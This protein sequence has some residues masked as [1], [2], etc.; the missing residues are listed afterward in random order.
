[1]F[2][3]RAE[4]GETRMNYEQNLFDEIIVDGFCGG[5]T[6]GFELVNDM[7]HMWTSA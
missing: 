5:G 3:L 7:E 4:S 6:R 1:M 2:E